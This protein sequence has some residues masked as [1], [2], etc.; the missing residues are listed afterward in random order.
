MCFS[1]FSFSFF[2]SISFFLFC[3]SFIIFLLYLNFFKKSLYLYLCLP[4]CLSM[5]FNWYL[6]SPFALTYFLSLSFTF[7]LYFFHLL[8][9]LSSFHIFSVFRIFSISLILCICFSIRV[10]VTFLTSVFPI[11]SFNCFTSLFLSYF[12]TYIPLRLYPISFNFFS[13]SDCSFFTFFFFFIIP[14]LPFIF[15]FLF[16]Y[17][18]FFFLCLPFSSFSFF[19][20]FSFFFLSLSFPSFFLSLSL[21]LFCFFL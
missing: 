15:F 10:H 18:N 5:L 9:P 6:L 12:H 16:L 19:S 17:L 8:S 13:I 3:H 4:V 2:V 20:F 14:S 21:S 11:L 1:L 7:F